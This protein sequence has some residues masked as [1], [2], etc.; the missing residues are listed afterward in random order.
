MAALPVPEGRQV[1]LRAGDLDRRR[2]RGL[3]GHRT[4]RRF[5]IRV[6]NEN[7]GRWG[8]TN[9]HDLYR[10]RGSIGTPIV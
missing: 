10:G 5:L 9:Y 7:R 8:V 6:R 2:H 1:E 3:V 4:A